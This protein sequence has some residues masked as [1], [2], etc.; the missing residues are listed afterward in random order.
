MEFD[1]FF[2]I[3]QTPD[4]SGH[5]PS[6]SQ[7]FTNFF[8]QVKI[9]DDLGF[10]VGWVAQAHLSTEVQ[11]TNNKPGHI[12]LFPKRSWR[13]MT[14]VLRFCHITLPLAVSAF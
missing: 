11:K 7:M 4:S 3:S 9:A 1:I 14:C 2:S 5:T 6:E 13:K 10:G 12:E 8:D